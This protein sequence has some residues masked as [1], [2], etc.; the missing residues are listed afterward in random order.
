MED[1][2]VDKLL[3]EHKNFQCRVL[4]SGMGRYNHMHNEI[5]LIYI[6]SG[7]VQ[8]YCDFKEYTLNAGDFLLVFPNTV[9]SY[10]VIQ[11]PT[12]FLCYFDKNMFPAFA[13]IFGSS[14]IDGSPVIHM[15]SLHSEV[16]YAINQIEKRG[17]L[18]RQSNI[19][20]GY[21]TII[22]EHLLKAVTLTKQE[23][24]IQASW[25]YQ[26]LNY[27]NNHFAENITL[28]I[29]STKLNISKYHISR[30]FNNVIGCSVIQYVNRLRVEKAEQL[31]LTTELPVTT[32][33]FECGFDSLS[34]FFRVFKQLKGQSPKQCRKNK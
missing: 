13:N 19:T 33:G 7:T 27:I 24:K 20:H 15:S 2:Q 14:M 6:F 32:I 3:Y 9:H 28:D 11:K 22:L 5:E 21:L 23:D 25:V 4:T 16:E 31:L 17:D 26:A 30:T 1:L 29:L 12:H 34:S 10:K 8:A 18:Q